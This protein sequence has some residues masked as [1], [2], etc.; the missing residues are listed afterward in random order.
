M[1]IDFS[2]CQLTDAVLGR[3]VHFAKNFNYS[4]YYTL[5]LPNVGRNIYQ[6][7]VLTGEYAAGNELPFKPGSKTTKYD[8]TVF[9][10]T[11][12]IVF[13]IFSENQAYPEYL[14]YFR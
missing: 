6:C 12:P 9:D 10:V 2:F 4:A 7:K 1:K 3:G 5:S 11:N 13:F 8:S 14:I